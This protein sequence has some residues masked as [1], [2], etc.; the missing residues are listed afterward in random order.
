MDGKVRRRGSLRRSEGV[1]ERG[2]ADRSLRVRYR[3]WSVSY[4]SKNNSFDRASDLDTF[5]GSF[6]FVLKSVSR[7]YSFDFQYPKKHDKNVKGK[8]C[9][10]KHPQLTIFEQSSI[11]FIIK[12]IRNVL[13]WL[14]TSRLQCWL[15]TILLDWLYTNLFG[16]LYI[17]VLCWLYTRLFG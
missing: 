4:N 1:H 13:T 5:E 6:C 12:N 15:Y 10:L 2:V 16:W 11:S 8:Y 9:C 17:S 3:S 7:F 14:C